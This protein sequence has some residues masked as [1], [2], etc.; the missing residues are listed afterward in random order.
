MAAGIPVVSF[1]C[2]YGPMDII[3]D[4]VDGFLVPLG[5]EDML[6]ERICYLI[7]ND[8]FRKTMGASAKKNVRRF[9]MNRIIDEWTALFNSLLAN[10]PRT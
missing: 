6:A 4:G 1:A 10:R 7:E 3:S 2:P 5:D 8:T 9:S